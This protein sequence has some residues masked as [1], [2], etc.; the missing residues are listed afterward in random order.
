[1]EHMN[2]E[3]REKQKLRIREIKKC[4]R[5]FGRKTKTICTHLEKLDRLP[6]EEDFDFRMYFDQREFVY[7][8]DPDHSPPRSTEPKHRPALIPPHADSARR[9]S[10]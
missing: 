3:F 4:V 10:K 1:M 5:Y 2:S 7:S 8:G 6:L 9:R